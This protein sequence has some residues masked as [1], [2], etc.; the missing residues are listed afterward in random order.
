MYQVKPKYYYWLL[1]LASLD[2][3]RGYAA[4]KKWHE[5]IRR[6]G[7]YCRSVGAEQKE[8]KQYTI[9]GQMRAAFTQRLAERAEIGWVNGKAIAYNKHAEALIQLR[10]DEGANL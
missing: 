1:S 4:Y 8:F 9:S 2:P 7:Y 3:M 5:G 6:A 10:R